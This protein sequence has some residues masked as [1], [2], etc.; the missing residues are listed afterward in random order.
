MYIPVHGTEHLHMYLSHISAYQLF[1]WVSLRALAEEYE[2]ANQPLPVKHCSFSTN[3]YRAAALKQVTSVT[4]VQEYTSF[5]SL[6]C[7][8][9]RFALVTSQTDRQRELELKNFIFQGL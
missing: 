5:F 4:S 3:A 1:C 9:E 6:S 2:Q 8:L 7:G